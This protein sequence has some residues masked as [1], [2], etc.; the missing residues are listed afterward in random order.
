MQREIQFK[1]F[2]KI[3]GDIKSGAG[4]RLEEI[5]KYEYLINNKYNSYQQY[6]T[7]T[8]FF[9]NMIIWMQNFENQED[10]CS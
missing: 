3:M 8:T 4:P 10:S 1:I 9:E 6:E 7:G 2:N 5:R